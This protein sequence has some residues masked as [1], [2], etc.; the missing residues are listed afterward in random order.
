MRAFL[1]LEVAET[2]AQYGYDPKL[3]NLR[4]E[5]LT[6]EILN[7]CAALIL[8]VTTPTQNHPGARYVSGAA[9]TIRRDEKNEKAIK[10][11]LEK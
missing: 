10:V 7:T 9:E 6:M 2:L 5:T 8:C 4:S 11:M 1:P 3:P